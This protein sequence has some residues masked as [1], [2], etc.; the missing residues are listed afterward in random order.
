MSSA[1]S[2][3]ATQLSCSSA[4]PSV[5]ML[6]EPDAVG[7]ETAGTVADWRT[8][9]ARVV[10]AEVGTEEAALLFELGVVVMA[11]SAVEELALALE[12]EP[13]LEP[14]PEPP[15]VKSTQDS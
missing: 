5:G 10:G 12:L 14:E 8:L 9:V 7:V 2:R 11:T 4:V 3:L 1:F 6:I 15:T 13:E